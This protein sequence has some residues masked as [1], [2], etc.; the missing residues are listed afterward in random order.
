MSQPEPESESDDDLSVEE[1]DSDEWEEWDEGEGIPS[2]SCLFCPHCAADLTANLR[3][4]TQAHSFFVPDA[5]YVTGYG[6]AGHLPRTEGTSTRMATSSGP[7][8]VVRELPLE[9][10]VYV[11]CYSS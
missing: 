7:A 10:V 4:M 1:V 9:V 3:H 2:T 11:C 8:S 5:E 6:G